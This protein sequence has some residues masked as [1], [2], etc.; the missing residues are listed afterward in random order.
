MKEFNIFKKVIL[1]SIFICFFEHKTNGLYDASADQIR[2]LQKKSIN[3]KN[4]RLLECANDN[5]RLNNFYESTP[6]LADKNGKNDYDGERKNGY[7]TDNGSN[8]RNRQYRNP[9]HS[10]RGIDGETSVLIEEGTDALEC[11]PKEK[12]TIKKDELIVQK[13]PDNRVNTINPTRIE[14]ENTNNTPMETGNSFLDIDCQHFEREYTAITSK[15]RYWKLEY[16]NM[17]TK[18]LKRIFKYTELK[19]YSFL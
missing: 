4:S 16:D 13:I 9:S 18:A 1:F 2:C 6:N 8:K 3:L 15:R 7:L 14:S 5:E 19:P 10:L 11:I 17:Y 12:Y